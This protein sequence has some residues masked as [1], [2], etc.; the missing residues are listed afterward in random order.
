MSKLVLVADTQWVANQVE[1]ALAVGGWDI[2]VVTDPRQAAT[3]VEEARPSAVL[4]DMQVGS[5]GGMAVIRSI[6]QSA[7]VRPRL[8]LLL[9]RSADTF[10]AHRAGADA[11]VLKPI[12]AQELR[13]AL[14]GNEEE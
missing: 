4:V 11:Y 14:E 7:G 6:R 5:K 10:I 8:I 1:A 13:L 12:K 3:A 2:E 9:D